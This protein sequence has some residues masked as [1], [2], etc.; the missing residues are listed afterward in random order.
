MFDCDLLMLL[1]IAH[2]EFMF[3]FQLTLFVI[4]THNPISHVPISFVGIYACLVGLIGFRYISWFVTNDCMYKLPAIKSL[5]TVVYCIS[6]F[7]SATR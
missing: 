7:V 1:Q 6:V 4:N 3:S 2:L 5:F